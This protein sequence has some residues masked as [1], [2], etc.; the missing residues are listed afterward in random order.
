MVGHTVG[1]SR[2]SRSSRRRRSFDELLA[3]M[4][5]SDGLFAEEAFAEL[6]EQAAEYL[7]QL[8]DAFAAERERPSGLGFWLLELLAES[9]SEQAFPLYEELLSSNNESYRDGAV[10]GLEALEKKEARRLLYEH[11]RRHPGEHT[12]Y[13]GVVYSTGDRYDGYF[14]SDEWS[15]PG[16]ALQPFWWWCCSCGSEGSLHNSEAAAS[17]E[18]RGHTPRVTR[19]PVPMVT[20]GGPV[21]TAD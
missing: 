16:R 5:S 14:D 13:V 8:L 4:R 15:G 1:M 20:P 3:A 11:R 7:P 19:G 21:R 10:L 6:G 9:R 18:A 17:A 2:R 12:A